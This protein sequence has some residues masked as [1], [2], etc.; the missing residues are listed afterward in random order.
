MKIGG[1]IKDLRTR[2]KTTLK[3]LAKRTGLTASFLS[4]LERDLVLPSVSS[5]EKLAQAL[6]TNVG[7]FFEDKEEK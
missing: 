7:Y 4:Q 3:E 5:L 2:Q 1:K 6:N